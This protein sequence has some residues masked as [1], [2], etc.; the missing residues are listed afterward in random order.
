MYEFRSS[1]ACM[2]QTQL[3]AFVL[4]K[5]ERLSMKQGSLFVLF[6]F[7]LMRSTEPGC[8]GSC[9][10]SLWKALD[11]VGLFGKLLTRIGAWAFGSVTCGAKVLEY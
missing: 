8:I 10:W 5:Y 11:E 4:S 2:G 9:S 3:V 7:V 1:Q 6:C